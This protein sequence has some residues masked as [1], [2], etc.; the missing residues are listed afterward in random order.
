[1]DPLGG[2]GPGF[3]W[4]DELFSSNEQSPAA[5]GMRRP[6]ALGLGRTAACT[7]RQAYRDEPRP[8]ARAATPTR[9]P[10]PNQCPIG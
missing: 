2:E 3:F 5:A 6:I 8:E 7:R 1:M 10:G 4:A 9:R